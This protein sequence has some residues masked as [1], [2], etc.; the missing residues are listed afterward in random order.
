MYKII[1]SDQKEYGPIDAESVRQWLAE[2]RLNAQSLA[3]AEG[4]GQWQPL[5]AFP[6]LARQI[7]QTTAP[8]PLVRPPPAGTGGE[9][10]AT[11]IPYRN[12]RALLAYY[13]GIFSLFPVLGMF[14]GIA[15]F[16]LALQGLRLASRHPAA[17]GKVHAWIGI[18][19]GGI[20]GLVYLIVNILIVVAIIKSAHSR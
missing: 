14:L 6:E 1:G 10:I 18:V 17:K 7:S 15:A 11:I 5:A 8:P 13:L 2:G 3:R 9:T 12:P 19:C 20:F 4:A 16:I